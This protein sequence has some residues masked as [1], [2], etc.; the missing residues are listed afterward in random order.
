[1]R[2]VVATDR[3]PALSSARAG[4]A[5]AEAWR[6]RGAQVAVVPVGVA[7]AGLGDALVDLWGASTW[8]LQVGDRTVTVGVA[9]SKGRLDLVV[10]LERGADDT[11][12]PH[13]GGTSA[14]VGQAIRAALDES[15]VEGAVRWL[16]VEVAAPTWQDGGL[17]MLVELGLVL[18]DHA[19][20]ADLSRDHVPRDDLPRHDRTPGSL[21]LAPVR[22]RLA[23]ASLVLAAPVD[24]AAAPLVGLRGITSLAAHAHGP[25]DPALMLARDQ[26]LVDL[27][28]AAGAA[29]LA[30]APGSGAVGGLGWAVLALGGRVVTGPG[31]CRELAELDAT[32]ARADLVVTGGDRLDFGTMGGDVLTEL[33][34]VAEAALRPLVVVAGENFIS[35]RELRSM[36][37]EAAYPV[38]RP[39]LEDDD[40]TSAARGPITAGELTSVARGVAASWSW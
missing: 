38:R 19:P 40:L 10:S 23:G 21:D 20:R 6:D 34:A 33:R 28:A 16:V 12:G 29:D 27:G 22:S 2:V 18:S 25:F 7:G 32:V 17:G 13:W 39:S 26:G 30:T 36:G 1:M 14:V 3:Y 15:G 37:V 35:S 11:R 24:G 4:A 5:L 8:L 9:A 31:L